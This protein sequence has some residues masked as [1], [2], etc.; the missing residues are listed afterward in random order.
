LIFSPAFLTAWPTFWA[1][2]FAFSAALSVAFLPPRGV[3]DS[4]LG[5][6]LEVCHGWN[7]FAG[8]LLPLHFGDFRN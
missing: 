7:S 6:V 5:L 8:N 4:V 2:S 3:V 1:P